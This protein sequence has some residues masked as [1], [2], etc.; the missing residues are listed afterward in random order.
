MKTDIRKSQFR[1]SGFRSFFLVLAHMFFLAGNIIIAQTAGERYSMT[2]NEMDI[3]KR[4]LDKSTGNNL[5][6]DELANFQKNVEHKV[7]ELQNCIKLIG[8]KTESDDIRYKAIESGLKL[9]IP[10]AKMQVSIQKGNKIKTYLIE[11][12]FYRLM[13]LPYTN[14]EIN[15]YDLAYISNFYQ[16][17]DG[18]YHATATIFQEFKGYYGDEVAY[19][20]RTVKTIDII[21]EY[22]EDEFFNIK[23]W[24]VKLGNIKVTETT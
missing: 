19:T 18:A 15:F 23:R 21:L 3:V 24:I 13:S 16:G 9:F 12:Y 5:S 4:N 7:N 11:D 2:S 8:S 6:K 14:V 10:D 22:T 17:E 1:K 20:D